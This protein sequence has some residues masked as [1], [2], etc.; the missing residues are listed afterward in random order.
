MPDGFIAAARADRRMPWLLRKA[1][2][3]LW[4]VDDS[5]GRRLRSAIVL[6]ASMDTTGRAVRAAAVRVLVPASD[7][8]R[9]FPRIP[10]AL[11]PLY[12]AL[13]PFRLLASCARRPPATDQTVRIFLLADLPQDSAVSR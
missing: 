7:D 9:A 13:R 11:H 8:W 5:F 1:L 3:G 10:R 6:L 2:D 12:Y 4:N